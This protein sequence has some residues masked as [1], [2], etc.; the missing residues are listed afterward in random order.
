MA[1]TLK[2]NLQ[3]INEIVGKGLIYEIP[4]DT[5]NII[6]YLCTEVGSP[7]I[8]SNI[9]E[10]KEPT[11]SFSSEQKLRKRRGNKTMEVSNEEWESLR[12]FQETKI[13]KKVGIAAEI[14]QLRLLLNK[15]TDKTYLDIREKIIEKMN[16]LVSAEGFSLEDSNKI[17][18]TIYD[19]S[20]A[21]KFYS[22]IYADLYAE[23]VTQYDWLRPLF[24]SKL[25]SLF[26][27]YC[28]IEYVDPDVDYDRFCDINKQNEKRRSVTTFYLNLSNNGFVSRQ[29]VVSMT[30]KLLQLIF[31][32]IEKPNMKN[33]VDELTENIS[34][35]F[36]KEMIEEFFQTEDV[37]EEDYE[38]DTN[39]SII[40]GIAKLAKM[41]AKDYPSLSNKAI[42]KY[43]DM[44]E[45]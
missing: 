45:M 32:F 15:L 14:D 17:S 12:T 33:Q 7:A 13:E 38:L 21:N 44:V 29:I 23:L 2:Y 41:K 4:E 24:N 40:E 10:R 35:L 36:N 37:D 31:D 16:L 27:Q 28:N 26:D 3:Q 20:S 22:K 1:A 18:L 25:E 6:N 30:K 19:I 9:Y 8:L 11:N 43:M 42:F 34:I 39:D 5:I